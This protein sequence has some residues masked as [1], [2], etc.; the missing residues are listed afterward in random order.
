MVEEVVKRDIRQRLDV[1]MKAIP[2]SVKQG[3]DAA[4]QMTPQARQDT[5]RRLA[6][7][8]APQ[9]IGLLDLR[10][11]ELGKRVREDESQSDQDGQPSS[12]IQRM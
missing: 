11:A 8:Y 4:M 7:L 6:K 10:N 2:V 12:K 5:A 9:A 3:V 1:V